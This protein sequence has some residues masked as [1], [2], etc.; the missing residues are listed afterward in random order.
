MTTA[1]SFYTEETNLDY[2]MPSVRF[3]F[4]DLTGDMYSD[5]II[6]TSLVNAITFIQS[7]WGAKYQVYLES[8]KVIPQPD[9]VPAGY[10]LANTVNGTA[11]IPDNLTEGSVFRNP[12][13]SFTQASPPVIQSDDEWGI[14]LAATLLL[15]RVQTSSSLTGFVSWS[16]EDIRYSN[17]GSE[18]GLDKLL[19]NDL[20][21]F[22]SYFATKIARPQRSTFPIGYIPGLHDL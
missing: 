10:I 20:E 8:N 2:L 15:R 21:A 3:V 13:L 11:Y 5:M 17:L 1:V 16:T 7:K 14:I 18:R 6:R 9:N 4:G 22:T 12:Y 19:A